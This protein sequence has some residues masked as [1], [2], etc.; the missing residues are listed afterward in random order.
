MRALETKGSQLF[1]TARSATNYILGAPCPW[2]SRDRLEAA[3][4]PGVHHVTVTFDPPSLAPW[5]INRE[6]VRA[7]QSDTKR[8]VDEVVESTARRWCGAREAEVLV[9]AWRLTDQAVR[10]F[11]DVPLYGTSWAFPLY[12]HW[13]RPFV[14]NILAIPENERRYY[15][16]HMIA[17][18]NNPTMIDF[19]ADALWLLIDMEQAK[20]IVRRCDSLVWKPLDEAIGLLD[21]SLKQQTQGTSTCDVLQD[22]RDRLQGLRCYFR[23]LRNTAGWI[24]GV[25]GYMTASSRNAQAAMLVSVRL[26]IDD[27]LKNAEDLLRL[28]N[29][30]HTNFMPVASLGENWA[31][32]GSNLGELLQKKIDLMKRHR[33]DTPFIDPNF[34]WRMGP[35]CPVPPAEYL[36]Y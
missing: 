20:S 34:M 33:E 5:S 19:S 7:Y 9:R 35:E 22:Q 6:I 21:T 10:S 3:V 29:A 11:P 30:S 28:W 13:V 12:R 18:F 17:T 26:M 14:P 36:K 27:E 16:Q 8:T 25:R 23:T 24:A 4:S 32:Y 15:E 2:L 1:G 31:F